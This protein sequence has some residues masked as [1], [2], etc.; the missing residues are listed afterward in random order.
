M[1]AGAL[2]AALAA[3]LLPLVVVS[4]PA[5]AADTGRL[6]FPYF[7]EVVVA[8]R[9]PGTQIKVDVNHA[10][11]PQ[12]Q[13]VRWTSQPS[14][15]ADTYLFR[16]DQTGFI[17]SLDAKMALDPLAGGTRA[18]NVVVRITNPG[19]SGED[20]FTITNLGAG[21]RPLAVTPA[22]APG[23]AQRNV[24]RSVSPYEPKF[25]FPMDLTFVVG[26]VCR[27]D[28]YLQVSLEWT[29]YGWLTPTGIQ[30]GTYRA[31]VLPDETVVSLDGKT[32]FYK[33][34]LE[35]QDRGNPVFG[36][37]IARACD[38]VSN[39]GIDVVGFGRQA[40]GSLAHMTTWA[41]EPDGGYGWQPWN[42]GA[43]GS[44]CT[45][46]FPRPRGFGGGNKLYQT[47]YDPSI[48]T[49]TNAYPG[50]FA[51]GIF[52]AAGR[53]G[54]AGASRVVT[55]AD[56]GGGPHVRVFSAD[57]SPSGGGFFAYPGGFLGGVRVAVCDVD[58][59]SPGDEIIVAPGR[60]GGPNVKVFAGDAQGVNA[61]P[62]Y[63]FWAYSTGWLGGVNLACGDVSGDG[64]A[65]IVTGVGPGGGPNARV[66]AANGT[67]LSSF[68]AYDPGF[69]GGV[70][71]AAGRFD[72]AGA[73]ERVVTGVG[74]GG[75]PHVRT[76]LGDGT[77]LGGGFF[78]FAP[79]QPG[80]VFVSAGDVTGD[81]IDEIVV[82]AG[83]GAARVRVLNRD[84]ASVRPDQVAF[85]SG[86]EQG[87]RVAVGDL[88][89]ARIVAGQ[90]PGAQPW[91]ALLTP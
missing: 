57:G 1:L 10:S 50:G 20:T 31:R 3:V 38:Q 46:A 79:S 67:L 7:V 86:L 39:D 73:K 8:D 91:W 43:P 24:V 42:C 76:F 2:A 51:G 58:A 54:S 47:R 61:A 26:S 12:W 74:A 70:T 25:R 19:V 30:P 49:P 48:Q 87:V 29:S 41:Q 21:S 65:E 18:P 22:Y 69:V 83:A 45:G 78:G 90:G 68:W 72:G 28:T 27:P 44:G 59:S 32:T 9:A 37:T 55:G 63:S 15:V 17:R 33:R 62:L 36:F 89:S 82:G 80:G 85:S 4:A 13:N 81:G 16:L 34:L 53:P 56:A 14:L 11:D 23:S 77:A 60:G 6:A 64:R 84:G 40:D 88:P 66:F 35:P 5:T 52:V 75:G 71:V